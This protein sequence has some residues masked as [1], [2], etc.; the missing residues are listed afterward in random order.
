MGHETY[1]LVERPGRFSRS[2]S[3]AAVVRCYKVLSLYADL[4]RERHLS[5]KDRWFQVSSLCSTYKTRQAQAVSGHHDARDNPCA[6]AGLAKKVKV[7]SV[8]QSRKASVRRERIC[9]V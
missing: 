7:S 8:W 2:R 3:R 5:A 6:F 4:V 1:S 9:A